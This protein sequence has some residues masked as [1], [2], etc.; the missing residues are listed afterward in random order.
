MLQPKKE[1]FIKNFRGRRRGTAL[2]GSDISFG[3]FGLKAMEVAWISAQQIEACRKAISHHL[4]RGGKMWIRIF[5]DKPISG[6]AAGKRMGGGK[7]EVVKHGAVVKPGRIMFEVAGAPKE[8]VKEAFIRAS[9]KLPIA[10]R[11]VEK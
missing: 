11:M 3:D 5:P 1:K 4:K 7:G 6:R 8:I 2:R 9:A 10:V